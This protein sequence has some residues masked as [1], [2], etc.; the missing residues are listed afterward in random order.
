M[1]FS[2]SS[3]SSLSSP[4]SCRRQEPI[5]TTPKLGGA[6]SVVLGHHIEKV[7]ENLG[8]SIRER[9]DKYV[10]V[11]SLARAHLKKRESTSIITE[12][13]HKESFPQRLHRLLCETK[14]RG[15]TDIV[16]FCSHG[17]AFEIHDLDRFT[18]EIMPRYFKHSKITSFRRQLSLYCF[19]RITAGADTGAYYHELFLEIL[20]DASRYM[21]RVGVPAASVDRRKRDANECPSEGIINFYSMESAAAGVC[22]SHSSR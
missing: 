13:K 8:S 10:D 15:E 4:S 18:S 20:P 9:N 21:R 6:L 22:L 19:R 14:A 7:L 12:S 1:A 17:R 3:S 16:S 5:G 11:L 2:S